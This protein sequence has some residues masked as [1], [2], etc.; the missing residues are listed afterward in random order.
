MVKF[1]DMKIIKILALII[2]VSFGVFMFVY[3]EYD[4][5]PGGQVLGVLVVVIPTIFLIRARKKS[6]S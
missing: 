5:S 2:V 3:G 6:R 4:D 1:L